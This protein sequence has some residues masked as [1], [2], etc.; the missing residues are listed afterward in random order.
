MTVKGTVFTNRLVVLGFFCVLIG[1][2]LP[3][4]IVLRMIPST[5]FLNFLAFTLSTAGLFLG[6]MGIATYVGEERRKR[7]DD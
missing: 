2:V 1:A 4:L 5:F 7:S 3:F 6:V